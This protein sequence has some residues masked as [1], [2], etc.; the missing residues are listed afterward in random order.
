V[1]PGRRPV[2]VLGGLLWVGAADGALVELHA[3]Q[4][5][6][7]DIPVDRPLLD[8]APEGSTAGGRSQQRERRNRTRRRCRAAPPF[9]GKSSNPRYTAQKCVPARLPCANCGRSR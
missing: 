7:V 5:L 9:G 2:H 3:I 4:E 6:R 8:F 1:S